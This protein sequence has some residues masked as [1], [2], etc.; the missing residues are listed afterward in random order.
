M[1]VSARAP[2]SA[3]YL[4][5]YR[6][7][8]VTGEW[9][10]I[11]AE[12]AARPMQFSEAV[13]SSGAS[14]PCP[15]CPGNE[16]ETPS[17]V[18]AYRN[19]GPPDSPGW[20]VRVVPNKYPA[21]VRKPGFAGL[22]GNGP[23]GSGMLSAP[24][25]GAHEVVIETPE[26]SHGFADLSPACLTAV[27]AAYRDRMAAFKTD[28]SVQSAVV[29]KNHGAAAGASLEHGHSQIVA[30][31]VVP[32]RIHLELSGSFLHH[33]NTG[34]CVFC[35][36]L[37][38]ESRAGVRIVKESGGFMA[39]TPYAARFPYEVWILP[40]R[41]A[42]HFEHM[43]KTE[44]GQAAKFL[45]QILGGINRALGSPAF[46][47]ILHSAPLREPDLP[48]Y[49]WHIEVMPKISKIAGFEWGSGIFINAVRPERAAEVLRALHMPPAHIAGDS[50]G[51]ERCGRG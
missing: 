28:G 24:G 7:D 16:R 9:V 32:P 49:H 12:R 36:L 51:K 23:P 6:R 2:G 15:F 34:A 40:K 27:F 14:G 20:R 50:I 3:D 41:H 17:E 11:A 37:E 43:G 30:L 48:H 22:P 35:A 19:G 45:G 13:A 1:G 47:F 33:V 38:E 10:I 26:H 39:L 4:P 8:P 31:P 21:L 44:L 46:N 25:F 42:S 5:E 29:F 18:L